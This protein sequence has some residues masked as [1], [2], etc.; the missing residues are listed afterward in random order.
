MHICLAT[1]QRGK[2][3]STTFT[4]DTEVNNCF[5]NKPNNYWTKTLLSVSK[6][7][8]EAIVFSLVWPGTQVSGQRGLLKRSPGTG[9]RPADNSASELTNQL[10]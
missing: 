7:T 3:I 8:W 6:A 9:S 4:D 10:V 1:K 2:Y 5:N